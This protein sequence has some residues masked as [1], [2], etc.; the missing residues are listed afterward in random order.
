M[1]ERNR[2]YRTPPWDNRFA[3]V[4]LLVAQMYVDH[5]GTTTK[6]RLIPPARAAP[7][8]QYFEVHQPTVP[9]SQQQLRYAE[10]PAVEAAGV[11]DVYQPQGVRA[12][13]VGKQGVQYPYTRQ[14]K[15]TL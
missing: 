10:I 5:L 13:E 15:L 4:K 11:V 2:D 3:S 14:K 7:P 12:P 1:A 8:P 9:V 6:L